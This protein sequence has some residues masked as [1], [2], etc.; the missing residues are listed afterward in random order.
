MLEREGERKQKRC[1]EGIDKRTGKVRGI[2]QKN[3]RERE[4]ETQKERQRDRETLASRFDPQHACG[5]PQH[6]HAEITQNQGR[7]YAH[8]WA[9]SDHC[10]GVDDSSKS[11]HLLGRHV[12]KV[13]VW[14]PRD[15]GPLALCMLDLLWLWQTFT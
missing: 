14:L 4:R 7:R 15:L 2:E 13:I 11:F 3:E 6:K 10:R 8:H 9:H 5:S 1:S 12:A